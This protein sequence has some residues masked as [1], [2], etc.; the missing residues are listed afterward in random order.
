MFPC[1]PV[2]RNGWTMSTQFNH[3]LL[4]INC[5]PCSYKL[6]TVQCEK[7]HAWEEIGK[8]GILLSIYT[9]NKKEFSDKLIQIK[10]LLLFC[11]VYRIEMS[12]KRVTNYCRW[13]LYSDPSLVLSATSRTHSFSNTLFM[14]RRRTTSVSNFSLPNLKQWDLIFLYHSFNNNLTIAITR[15]QRNRKLTLKQ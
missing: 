11:P 7:K 1:E 6:F 10:S 9:I 14:D 12:R 4:F 5:C 15:K 8:N 2:H 3:V 13:Y